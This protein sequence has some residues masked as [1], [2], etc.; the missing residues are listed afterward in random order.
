MLRL[1]SSW[2]AGRGIRRSEAPTSG[3][4]AATS[5]ITQANEIPNRTSESSMSPVV[6][7][8]RPATGAPTGVQPRASAASE[9]PA[10]PGF[11]SV[12]ATAN[13]TRGRLATSSRAPIARSVPF[14]CGGTS[15]FDSAEATRAP[16]TANSSTRRPA[17]ASAQPLVR[18]S[19]RS[20]PRLTSQSTSQS[21]GQLSR[22]DTSSAVA[23]AEGLAGADPNCRG[24]RCRRFAKSGT[25]PATTSTRETSTVS[26]A[27]RSSASAAMSRGTQASATAPAA[28][29]I[30]SSRA[31]STR[32]TGPRNAAASIIR[33]SLQSRATTPAPSR[34]PPT[35]SAARS[36]P[37][38]S[39]R[40]APSRRCPARQSRRPGS[41]RRGRTRAG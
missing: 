36:A 35:A 17:T 19:G 40:R 7:R 6:A 9:A 14:A 21:V 30:P 8:A 37:R 26:I 31:R 32:G 22:V 33:R 1:A 39:H 3:N 12:S 2:S 15:S 24:S 5:T 27:A 16:H 41:R 20:T 11:L 13:T 25:T 23:I 10:P 4:Q 34:H 38:G 29:R 28:A 18:H